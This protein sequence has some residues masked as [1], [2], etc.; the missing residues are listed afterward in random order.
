[1]LALSAVRTVAR[2]IKAAGIK[3]HQKRVSH[4][5]NPVRQSTQ[6][7][8]NLLDRQVEATGPNQK[9]VAYFTNVWTGEG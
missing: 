5:G 8:L 2:L 3:G 4:Q 9:R 6:L 1:M 7:R